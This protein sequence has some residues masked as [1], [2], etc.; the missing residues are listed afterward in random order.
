MQTPV[1]EEVTKL[2]RAW[3]DGDEKAMARLLPLVQPELHRLAK[4]YLRGERPGHTLQTTALVNEAYLRLIDARKVRWQDRAHFFGLSARLMRQ[5]LVDFAR[6]RGYKKRGGGV[7]HIPLDEA[8]VVSPQRDDDL[9]AL[10][11]ALA[12]LAEVD[13]RKSRVVE[14]RYFGGLTVEEAAG[15]LGV[16][17]E[18]V[19]RDWRLAKAWLRRRLSEE[20]DAES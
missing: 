12:A 18:T 6:S 17:P 14:L 11:E 9:V 19:R 20:P 13:A 2:L 1:S 10:D 8:P 15:V 3:S 4:Q 5:I 16:S 7:R